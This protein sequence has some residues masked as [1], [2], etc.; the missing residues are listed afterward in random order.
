M[1]CTR[2]QIQPAFHCFKNIGKTSCGKQIWYTRPYLSIEK[3]FT[4]ES[5]S[6]YL[7]HMDE[8]SSEPWIWIFDATGFDK[9]EMPNPMLMKKFY[10]LIEEKYKNVLHRLYILNINW[11]VAAILKIVRPFLKK[12]AQERLAE[13]SNPLSLL[14]AGV[15]AQI[16][17]QVTH[18]A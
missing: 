8:A 14:S 10:H 2:C 15:P 6:N 3:K 7:F 11:K 4:E 12:E 5:I 17:H 16:V 9:L 18:P 13:T 1:T